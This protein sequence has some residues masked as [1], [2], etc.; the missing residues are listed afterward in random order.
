MERERGDG[1]LRRRVLGLAEIQMEG[2]S[3]LLGF[4]IDRF[5][6]W[7]ESDAEPLTEIHRISARVHR[8]YEAI[9]RRVEAL[10]AR[11]RESLRS[12]PGPGEER[13]EES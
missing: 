12:D 7:P 10:E 5:E 1:A 11:T 2:A 9:V 3:E 4:Y 8:C 13:G 6:P